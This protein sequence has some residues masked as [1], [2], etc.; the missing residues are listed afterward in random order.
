MADKL[1]NLILENMPTK[2]DHVRLFLMAMPYWGVVI[3]VF[4]AL[5][6]TGFLDFPAT[7]RS[8]QNLSMRVETVEQLSSRNGEAVRN[9]IALPRHA[10]PEIRNRLDTLDEKVK[11]IQDDLRRDIEEIKQNQAR[12]REEIKRGQE[13][14]LEYLL[15]KGGGG[16]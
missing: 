16:R 7:A 10:T 1:Q 6:A 12:D 15:N 4:S 5:A 9:H 8:V 14:I 2:A 13:V 11:Q 3:A